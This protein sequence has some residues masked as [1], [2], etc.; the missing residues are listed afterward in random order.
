MDSAN[1]VPF[2]A[3]LIAAIVI[4]VILLRL[5]R[6]RRAAHKP[7]DAPLTVD[8]EEYLDSSH[9]IHRTDAATRAADARRNAGNKPR[10]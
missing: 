1:I 8:E 9:I 3:L 2:A 6:S 10:S 5:M 4:A 7:A